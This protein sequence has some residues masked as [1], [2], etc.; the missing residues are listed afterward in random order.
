MGSGRRR[1]REYWSANRPVKASKY[2]PNHAGTRRNSKD[3]HQIGGCG[4]LSILPICL[5]GGEGGESELGGE[6]EADAAAEGSA[7][8]GSA[9]VI[10]RKTRDLAVVWVLPERKPVPDLF[11]AQC[12][13][14]VSMH[15]QEVRKILNPAFHIEKLKIMVPAMQFSC[16]LMAQKWEEI[17]LNKEHVD[18]DVWPFLDHLAGDMISRAAFGSSYNEGLQISRIQKEQFAL[19]LAFYRS[20]LYQIPGWRFLPTKSTRM[21]KKNYKTVRALVMNIIEQRKS[22]KESKADLLGI[23]LGILLESNA[24]E[25]EESKGSGISKGMSID[26]VVGE[27]KLFYMAGEEAI[28][29]FLAWTMILLSQHQEWQQRA[30]D[31]VFQV[32]GAAAPDFD[33]L[34]HLKIVAMIMNEVLR[35]YPPP[36][37]LFRSVSKPIQLKDITLLPGMTLYLP[38]ALVHRDPELWGDDANEFKPERFLEGVSGTKR[39][40]GSFFAF[41]GGARSCIGQN[42]ALLEAKMA[43]AI[44][45]WWFSF[46]LSPTCT[47]APALTMV[48]YP[49]FGANLILRKI[50]S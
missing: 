39:T 46:E 38:L 14:P 25:V 30:R 40:P 41:G 50:R 4:E 23:L 9:A 26:D 33:G 22:N 1:R 18:I 29:S 27:V 28:S 31:E 10:G 13:E 19:M 32:F 48:L 24:K 43:L 34:S 11:M 49:Q 35:L 6:G 16:E 47:H 17:L 37:I 5:L 20:K 3:L 15:H 2:V 44:I 45:L 36:G 21:M 8:E 7:A 12:R 42:F